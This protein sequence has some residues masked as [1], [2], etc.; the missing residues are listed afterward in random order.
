ME[1]RAYYEGYLDDAMDTMGNMMDYALNTCGMNGEDFFYMFLASGTARQFELGNP[2]YLAGMTGAEIV[3]E[4]VLREKGIELNEPEEYDL[5][6][7][8]EYWCGWI[9]AYYQWRT[10][11]SFRR[12]RQIVSIEEILWMYPTHHEADEEH[13][14]DTMNRL[15]QRR[16]T[17]TYLRQRMEAARISR[18]ELS[19]QAGIP[20]ET[21]RE[22]EEDDSKI[23]SIDARSLFQI[24]KVLGCTMEDLM[25]Y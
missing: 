5:D 20:C 24:S 17:K 8:P 19:A 7:S 11:R 14:V 23:A 13:F 16:H 6:K 22:L 15:Y 12:I 3:R 4:I 10:C 2:R 21:I 9:L 18:E 1:I 25:E